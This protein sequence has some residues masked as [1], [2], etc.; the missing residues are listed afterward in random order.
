MNK[1]MA[2]SEQTVNV[3]SV[4]RISAGTYFKGEVSSPFDLR[5]DGVFEGRI[6]SKGKVV[7]GETACVTGDVIC[8]NV[9]LWGKV[10]G[11]LFIKDTLS[12][13]NGCSADGGLNV[14]RLFVEL[15]SIFN[16]TCRMITEKEYDDLVQSDPL[17]KAIE[18]GK[19][20]DSKHEQKK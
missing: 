8:E 6:Y 1:Y 19:S 10:K 7:I 5:I 15:G 11:N 4:S 14:R 16:G 9:D 18:G 13:K 12:L 3:N 2:K 17:S 20:Q